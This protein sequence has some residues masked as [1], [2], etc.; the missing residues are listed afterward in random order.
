LQLERVRE[1]SMLQFKAAK[2]SCVTG[3][4]QRS[5]K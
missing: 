1:G 4:T 3:S 2:V 5:R